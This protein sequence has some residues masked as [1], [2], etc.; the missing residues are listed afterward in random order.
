MVR[1]RQS[2][3]CKLARHALVG[4]QDVLWLQVPVEDAHGMAVLDG[5]QDLDKSALDHGIVPHK[6]ALLGDVGEQVTFRAVFN[7]NI[8]A[9]W[10]VHDF[11]QGNHVGMGTGLVVELD[12][13]LLELALTRFQTDL[14][15]G[16]D[17]I[18]HVGLDVHGCV[19]DSI[20]S[21]TEN[22]C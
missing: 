12:L 3:V 19:H 10:G 9:V 5:V 14:V 17:G 8:G 18:G 13:P 7:D 1:S 22:A 4:D 20:G 16:L 2:K 11:D 6:L 15:Q 21:D